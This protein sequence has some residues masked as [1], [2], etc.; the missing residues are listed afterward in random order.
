MK[1]TWPPVSGFGEAN[2][3]LMPGSSAI[4]RGREIISRRRRFTKPDIGYPEFH[5]DRFLE[6]VLGGRRD[7]NS[8]FG[9]LIPSED[10]HGPIRRNGIGADNVD[11]RVVWAIDIDRH[12]T[13]EASLVQETNRIGVANRSVAEPHRYRIA[14]VQYI[15]IEQ[16][17]RQQGIEHKGADACDRGAIDDGAR[18]DDAIDFRFPGLATL[19]IDVVVIADQPGFPADFPH[20]G[21][22][23]IDTQTAL[24]AA[25]LRAIADIDPGWTDGNA[26]IA[27][28]AVADGFA[29]GP[30]I[31]RLLQ[32]GAFFTPV[33]F[34]G[35]V[36]RP[37]VGERCLDTRPRAHVDADLFAHEPGEHIG[38]GRQ[39]TD[40]DIGQH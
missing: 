23:G 15:D 5:R 1:S 34:V 37:F 39:Y 32:R 18:P 12:D 29:K 24:D 11:G 36:Q 2:G 26:L 19:N 25:E 31:V 16:R 20:H 27:I 28:D 13:I 10:D 3:L 22:A 35:D 38:R 30:Q 21:I 40:P 4:L 17:P 7:E 33:V 14:V 8:Q 9:G 6:I